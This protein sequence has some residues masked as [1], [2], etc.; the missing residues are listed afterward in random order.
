MSIIALIVA[1]LFFAAAALFATRM[2]LR[3]KWLRAS[4]P[5]RRAAME[6]AGKV[7]KNAEAPMRA[8]KFALFV[9]AIAGSPSL[10]AKLSEIT[11]DF[12]AD[13]A[14]DEAKS[15]FISQLDERWRKPLEAALKNVAVATCLHDIRSAP[16]VYRHVTTQHMKLAYY[17]EE[18]REAVII[19][20]VLDKGMNERFDEMAIA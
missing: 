4:V 6:N 11:E 3:L 2:H 7:A 5:Y 1:A 14:S 10:S 9:F 8:R 12:V 19:A 18:K 16:A 15:P 17:K 20:R 13:P